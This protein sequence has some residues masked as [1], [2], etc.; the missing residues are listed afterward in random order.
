MEDKIVSFYK[1]K[2]YFLESTKF[3]CRFLNIVIWGRKKYLNQ[4]RLFFKEEKLL[5]GARR[6]MY[7]VEQIF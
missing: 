6:M 3:C 4:E 1:I 2:I 7:N 5:F